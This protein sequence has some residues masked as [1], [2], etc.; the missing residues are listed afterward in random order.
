MISVS[1]LEMIECMLAGT[2]SGWQQRNRIAKATR[3]SLTTVGLMKPAIATMLKTTG[4]LVVG[5]LNYFMKL[6]IF[7]GQGRKS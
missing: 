7:R 2:R 1:F 6:K 4:V 5:C 3:K